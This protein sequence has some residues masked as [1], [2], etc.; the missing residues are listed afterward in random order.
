MSH[1]ISFTTMFRETLNYKE[2]TSY[3]ILAYLTKTY[4]ILTR[5]N[6][7]PIATPPNKNVNTI[8]INAGIVKVI[9]F[10]SIL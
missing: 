8:S 9:I 4:L 1:N 7:T 3:R 2:S 10:F 6:Q 5:I